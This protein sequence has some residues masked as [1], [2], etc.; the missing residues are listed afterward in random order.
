[1]TP[2]MK[3]LCSKI[4]FLII[5]FSNC[6]KLLHLSHTKQTAEISVAIQACN[7]CMFTNRRVGAYAHV[8]GENV[9]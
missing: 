9:T 1:M 7:I 3:F 4:T 5:C 8:L 6:L 2:R